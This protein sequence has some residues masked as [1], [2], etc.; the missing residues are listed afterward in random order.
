MFIS[1]RDQIKLGI[2][3]LTQAQGCAIILLQQQ[4]AK[5]D[6]FYANT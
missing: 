1:H 3:N 4:G 6:L 2:I 5:H